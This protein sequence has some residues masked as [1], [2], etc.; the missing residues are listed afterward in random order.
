M[1][2]LETHPLKELSEC[3]FPKDMEKT[4]ST[5]T[6]D[7]TKVISTID[8]DTKGLNEMAKG[9]RKHDPPLAT[10]RSVNV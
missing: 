10:E 7:G 8:A 9:A 4:Q 1:H 6:V 3:F 5:A 2:A